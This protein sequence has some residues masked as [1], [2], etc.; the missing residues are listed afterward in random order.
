MKIT[1]ITPTANRA[2]FIPGLVTCFLQQDYADKELLI[3]DDGDE[4]I[5]QL[6]PP[7]DRIFY[8][9]I[10]PKRTVGEKR[11]ICCEMSRGEVIAHFDDD[12][13]SVPGRLT[14]QFN[15]LIESGK[16]VTGYHTFLYWDGDTA[17]RYLGHNHNGFAAGT[18]QM[19]FADWW[20]VH[21]FADQNLGED[22]KFSGKAWTL[23]QLISVDGGQNIVARAHGK[24]SSL[25]PLGQCGCPE[26]PISELPETFLAT[27]EMA[28]V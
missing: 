8:C 22:T 24:N 12:D 11:N 9:K 17:Y 10:G 13:W 23:K 7:D 19:Y 5:K 1:C 26:I 21:P 2:S 6:L 18:S 25:K 16:Q 14:E 3:L 28:H 20:K 4:P 15:C 27:L